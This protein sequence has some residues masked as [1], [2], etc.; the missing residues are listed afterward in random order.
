MKKLLT[1]FAFCFLLFG[2]S[3]A[4]ARGEV[5]CPSGGKPQE[6]DRL[7]CNYEDS[8]NHIPDPHPL[9][10]AEPRICQKAYFGVN[11]DGLTYGGVCNYCN[12]N[13][14]KHGDACDAT[15]NWS[16]APDDDDDDEWACCA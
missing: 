3:S 5:V 14:A 6:P 7:C 15:C 1:I 2:L 4:P 12:P 11:P 9:C 16:C 10:T 13:V 8:T